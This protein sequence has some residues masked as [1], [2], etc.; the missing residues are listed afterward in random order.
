MARDQLFRS[1]RELI[2]RSV[3]RQSVKCVLPRL[4]ESDVIQQVCMEAHKSL[5]TFRGR[6]RQDLVN[7]LQ[8]IVRRT[9]VHIQREHLAKRRDIR[10]DFFEL[11]NS[12]EISLVWK[13]RVSGS[14]SPSEVVIAGESAQ[15]LMKALTQLPNDY[16]NAIEMRFLDGLMLREIAKEQHATTGQI[17]GR[18]RRGL[19]MLH[20][21]L[22]DDFRRRF[23]MPKV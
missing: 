6:T 14:E 9:Q 19:T 10:R 7:W 4:D 2:R 8:T 15:Q 20:D 23:E 17:A 12:A 16:R 11:R 21:T 22:P 5:S 3:R 13:N 18:I 1:C